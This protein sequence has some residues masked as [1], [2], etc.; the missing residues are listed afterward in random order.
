MSDA[1]FDDKDLPSFACKKWIEVC[2]QSGEKYNV[3]K[4][5]RIKTPILRPDLRAFCDAYIAVKGTITAEKI[6]GR[7]NDGHN[8]LFAF[9]NNTLFIN[10]IS[11]INGE[12]IDN[13]NWLNTVKITEKQR[14]ICGIIT[15]TNQIMVI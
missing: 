4:K 11:K 8:K 14:E 6:A 3:N 10:C 15:E 7:I 13:S 1:T 2:H 5:I 12:L 9:K